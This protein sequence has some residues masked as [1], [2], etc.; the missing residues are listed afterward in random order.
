MNPINF[1]RV[2][3]LVL[4]HLITWPRSLERV[5]DAFWWPTMNLFIW[6]LVNVYLQQ[7]TGATTYFVQLFLG[8][9]IMW[10]LVSGCFFWHQYYLR[11]IYFH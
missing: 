3:A 11:L 9:L 2:Y 8:G 7:K 10:T 5:A 1:H 6:G 4:R